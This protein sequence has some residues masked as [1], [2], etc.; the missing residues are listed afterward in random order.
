MLRQLPETMHPPASAGSAPAT[1]KLNEIHRTSART[2]SVVTYAFTILFGLVALL[3]G[4]RDRDPVSTGVY[5]LIAASFPPFSYVLN[6]WFTFMPHHVDRDLG[7]LYLRRSL[8]WQTQT[9]FLAFSDV[10]EVRAAD[11]RI[12]PACYD[13]RTQAGLGG[14]F[15][16]S[17]LLTESVE[18]AM[19]ASTAEVVSE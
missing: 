1:M 16:R 8:L 11:S 10:V 15:V 19:L 6:R 3:V 4:L 7:G 13:V 14:S 17:V 2:V 12:K 5:L 18:R 9:A